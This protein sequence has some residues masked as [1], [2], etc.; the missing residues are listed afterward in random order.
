MKIIIESIPH[1]SQRY[2]TVGDWFYKREHSFSHKHTVNGIPSCDHCHATER[3][4]SAV[5]GPDC[6]YAP[7]TLHIRVSQFPKWQHEALIILH[8]LIEALMCENVG[9]GQEAI[10]TFDMTWTPNG[11]YLEPGDDPS[12]PYYQ[13]HQFASG[14]ERLLCSALYENWADYEASVNALSPPPIS[15]SPE[16]ARSAPDEE[17]EFDSD[18]PF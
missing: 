13:E 17:D 18:I 2:K 15:A 1:S 8:E 3:E 12:A 16:S 10:D 4:I 11:N 14:I 9:T 6:F 7:P 5:I